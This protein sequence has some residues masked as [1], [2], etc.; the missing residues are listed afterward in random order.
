MS[1]T[2]PF[3]PSVTTVSPMLLAAHNLF[4]VSVTFLILKPSQRWAVYEALSFVTPEGVEANNHIG[5]KRACK[6]KAERQSSFPLHAPY[7]GARCI[8]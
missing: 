5:A 8:S 4:S 7:R 2:L 1:H 6:E 3:P